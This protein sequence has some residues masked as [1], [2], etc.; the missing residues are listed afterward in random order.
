VVVSAGLVLLALTT[1][2]TAQPPSLEPRV[3]VGK[4]VSPRGTL[5]QREQPGGAWTPLGPKEDVHSRDLLLSLP[6]IQAALDTADGGVRLEL[7]GSLPEWPP[8]LLL[9]SAVILHDSRA[10]DLDFTLDRGRVVLTNRKK[11]GEARVWV[12]LP[13]MAWDLTLAEP[14]DQAALEVAAR[15]PHGIPFEKD[16]RRGHPPHLFIG[17]H[18]LKGGLTLKT[19][20]RQHSLSAPPGPA[21][22]SWDSIL[23]QQGPYRRERNPEWASAE[24]QKKLPADLRKELAQLPDFAGAGSVEEALAR[25]LRSADK[26]KDAAS[27][28]RRRLAVY[29]MAAV[30]D[31]P[32]LTDALADTHSPV[33]REAAIVALRHWIGRGPEQDRALYRF[34]VQHQ[35]YPETLADT[36]MQ[37]L[38]SPFDLDRPETYDALIAY[39]RHSRLPVRELARWHLYRLVPAG[40]KIVYDAA[41]SEAERQKGHAEWRK[42]IPSGTV[43]RKQAPK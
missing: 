38:H 8:L 17:L 30:D 14:G 19:G 24:I 16:S 41:A 40:R 10:Y 23:G 2:T 21:L 18:A 28:L 27:D 39:L 11:K 31:L 13:G 9:E 6:G 25:R 26:S 22:L 34:L 20:G 29:G 43:P 37:L 36:V 4:C 35:K 33:T 5:L 3:T 1:A 15:R 32:G 7:W 12:R 42:L